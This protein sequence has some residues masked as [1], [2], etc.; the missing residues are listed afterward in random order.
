M[1]LSSPAVVVLVSTTL[2]CAAGCGST[3][4]TTSPSS[5]P[6]KT[7]P[8]AASPATNLTGVWQGN[9]GVGA[10]ATSVTMNLRQEGPAV[11]GDIAV[12]GRPDMSGP[13]VGTVEGAA[14]RLRL[15]SGEG[16]APELR[17]QGDTISGVMNGEPL[18]ARRVR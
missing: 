15:Q 7:G 14:L 16:S 6:S 8:V 13:V 17:V 1:T 11:K 10:R 2:L 4:R 5:A 12:G 18:T 9:A 3:S